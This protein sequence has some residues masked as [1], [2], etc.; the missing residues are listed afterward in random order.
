MGFTFT[1][2]RDGHIVS[3]EGVAV[4]PSKVTSIQEWP[5]PKN[6]KQLHGFLGLAGYYRRFVARYASLAAPLTHLLRKDAFIWT[7]AATV[8][9]NNSKAA[10]TNTPVLALPDFSKPFLIQTDASR[11]GVGAVLSQDGHLIAYFSKQMSPR[12]Q[13]ASTYV[14]EMYAITEAVKR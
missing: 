10:M 7:N 12:L 1:T 13:Q 3:H 9:F 14:R 5:L 8:A 4:E 11:S 2:S 6:I